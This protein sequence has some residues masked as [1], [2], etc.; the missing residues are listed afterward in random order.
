MLFRSVD[1]CKLIFSYSTDETIQA[2]PI[3][4]STDQLQLLSDKTQPIVFP[5]IVEEVKTDDAIEHVK[6]PFWQ[7]AFIDQV[8]DEL[9]SLSNS[10]LII[11]LLFFL[12]GLTIF[13]LYGAASVDL[14]PPVNQEAPQSFD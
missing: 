10:K 9:S 11:Y 13:L 2:L 4:D 14:I 7:V 8:F 12:A 3:F 1:E 6:T 5:A